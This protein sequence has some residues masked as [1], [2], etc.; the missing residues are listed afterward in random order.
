MGLREAKEDGIEYEII[1]PWT[2]PPGYKFIIPCKKCGRKIKTMQYVRGKIYLCQYCKKMIN[3]KKKEE[4]IPD[5]ETKYDR[6][7]N[8]AVENIKKN[9]SDFDKY[10]KAIKLAKTRCYKYGSIPEAMAAIELLKHKYRIIPQQKID[11]YKVDFVLLDQ[12]IVLEIDGSLYHSNLENEGKRDV[13]LQ[14]KLGFEW[15]II[16]IP[17]EYIIKDIT[18]LTYVIKQYYKQIKKTTKRE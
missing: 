4:K 14:H 10:Q 2:N 6:R 12:K 15:V 3:E 16:H 17:A 18:K 1:R 13:I 9:V 7:F 8:K 5:I 11:K